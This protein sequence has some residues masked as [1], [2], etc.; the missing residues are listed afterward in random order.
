MI[1]G[2]HVGDEIFSRVKLV[3]LI[4]LEGKLVEPREHLNSLGAGTGSSVALG[5]GPHDD[6][7]TR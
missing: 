4:D 3:F 2:C 6:G 7:R 1:R 5:R